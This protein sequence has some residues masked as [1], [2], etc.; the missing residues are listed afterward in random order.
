MRAPADGTLRS[1]RVSTEITAGEVEV[2]VDLAFVA[3]GTLEGNYDSLV[4]DALKAGQNIGTPTPETD[5][6]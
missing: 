3:N 1:V 6:Q 4:E 2:S 5:K